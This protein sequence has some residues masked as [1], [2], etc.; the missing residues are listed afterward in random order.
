MLNTSYLHL[1]LWIL[2]TGHVWLSAEVYFH[3]IFTQRDQVSRSA[4]DFWNRMVAFVVVTFLNW[5]AA[6]WVKLFHS[7]PKYY[8]YVRFLNLT[9]IPNGGAEQLQSF[10]SWQSRK[11]VSNRQEGGS[12]ITYQKF[13]SHYSRRTSSRWGTTIRWTSSWKGIAYPLLS[14][15]GDC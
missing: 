3:L 6:T 14:E 10:Q 1:L 15:G 5:L 7:K 9:L 8:S 12:A 11:Q 2:W 4:S 13:C